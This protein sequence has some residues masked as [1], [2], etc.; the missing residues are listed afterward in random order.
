MW[1]TPIQYSSIEFSDAVNGV[2]IEREVIKLKPFNEVSDLGVI[3]LL[4]PVFICLLGLWATFKL[5]SITLA[6][7][8]LL[9]IVFWLITVFSIG[10]TYSAVV[11]LLIAAFAV[12]LMAK[13]HVK[14]IPN[15]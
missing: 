10:M 11:L 7:S 4:I 12:H 9:I 5:K 2:K 6:F 1:V 3:P 8:V 14:K 13:W 15:E